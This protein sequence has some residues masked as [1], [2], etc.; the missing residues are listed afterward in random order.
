MFLQKR[1]MSYAKNFNYFKYNTKI[2]NDSINKNI[3]SNIYSNIYEDNTIYYT[4]NILNLTHLSL[5]NIEEKKDLTKLNAYL[6]YHEKYD[7]Y[8]FMNNQNLLVLY[9]NIHIFTPLHI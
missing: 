7:N 5:D 8:I 3:N 1:F 9:E 4:N 2:I 6:N